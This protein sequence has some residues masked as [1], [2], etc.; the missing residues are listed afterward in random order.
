MQEYVGATEPIWT[1]HYLPGVPRLAAVTM[2]NFYVWEIGKPEPLLIHPWGFPDDMTMRMAFMRLSPDGRWLAIASAT[3]VQLWDIH[4]IIPKLHRTIDLPDILGIS[5]DSTNQL[6]IVTRR[7]VFGRHSVALNGRKAFAVGKC[8]PFAEVDGW[9]MAWDID[10]LWLRE[11]ADI[12]QNGRYFAGTGRT[13][14]VPIWDLATGEFV[15][16][17]KLR[18]GP[19]RIAFSN[20][21]SRLAIDAGTTIY[22]HD[23]STQA[24][25]TSWKTKYTYFPALAWSP[26]G[27]VVAR[28]ESSTT[29]YLY[30]A[31][32]GRQL[33][34]LTNKRGR[35]TAVA[36]APDG[37]T[38]AVGMFSGGVRIWDLE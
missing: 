34:A 30:E 2:P 35:N 6:Q 20:D 13:S 17:V 25:L 16:G 24:R 10:V 4:P 9:T 12:S 36:I 23:T 21:G 19:T 28:T 29:L 8:Q 18:R 33:A 26:D 14:L 15:G 22:V 7:P 5:F 31:V 32:T 27:R 1:I 3:F 37:L 38:C 11:T